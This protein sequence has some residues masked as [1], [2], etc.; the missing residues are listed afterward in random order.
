MVRVREGELAK[1]CNLCESEA[2]GMVIVDETGGLHHRVTSG[3][4]DEAKAELLEFLAH[5]HGFRC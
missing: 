2:A 3:R 1:L 5:A 4:S